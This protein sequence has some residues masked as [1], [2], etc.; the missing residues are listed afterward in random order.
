MLKHVDCY[1]LENAEGE[2]IWIAPERGFRFLQYE[3]RSALRIGNPLRGLDKGT[4]VVARRSAS[5]QKY[6]ELWFPKQ[7]LSQ[8][9]FIDEKGQERLL[10]KTSIETKDFQVNH[11]IPEKTFTVKI[12]DNALI[13]VGDLRKRLSKKE[14]QNLYDLEWTK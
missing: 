12:P 7:T 2:K 4:P 9:S 11:N 6:G 10:V 8:A 13:Y 1:V 5:Y 14:F 3:H